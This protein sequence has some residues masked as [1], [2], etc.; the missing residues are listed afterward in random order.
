MS[1]ILLKQTVIVYTLWYRGFSLWFLR[2]SVR[3]MS[4]ELHVCFYSPIN[5][6]KHIRARCPN[7]PPWIIRPEKL[8]NFSKSNKKKWKNSVS[9]GSVILLFGPFVL[10]NKGIQMKWGFKTDIFLCVMQ[11]KTKSLKNRHERIRKQLS[12]WSTLPPCV[13]LIEQS[14]FVLTF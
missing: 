13:V 4:F 11:Q 6:R 1:C 14:S 2:W 5:I 3:Q 9:S 10:Q 12:T 8:L 7:T